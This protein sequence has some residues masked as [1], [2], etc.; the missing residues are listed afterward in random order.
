M[1]EDGRSR[2]ANREKGMNEFD[3]RIATDGTDPGDSSCSFRLRPAARAPRWSLLASLLFLV[4]CAGSETDVETGDAADAPAVEAAED[5]SRVG[6]ANVARPRPGLLT[7]A[8]P[9]QAQ[10]DE[11]RSLGY[12]TF[13]SLRPAAEPGAGWEEAYLPEADFERIAISGPEDLTREHVEALDR[14]LAEADGAKAVL[15]CASSNRVGALMAL[16]ALWLEG[17]APDSALRVGRAAGLTSL[18]P[19]VRELLSSGG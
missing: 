10:I 11:L 2:I 5:L 1:A 7:S 4:A 13:I 6:L 14:A 12:E 15:Y 18:E 16:R 8:Q 3:T 19:A 17:V 9:S